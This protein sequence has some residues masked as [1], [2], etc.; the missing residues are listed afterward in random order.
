MI[1]PTRRNNTG[2]ARRATTLIEI[3]VAAAILASLMLVVMLSMSSQAKLGNDMQTRAYGNAEAQRVYK[4][5]SRILRTAA[6][7]HGTSTYT[8][9]AGQYYAAL[10]FRPIRDPAYGAN[11]A[12][13]LELIVADQ[14]SV[15]EVVDPA[16]AVF[17]VAFD[18]SGGATRGG[19]LRLRLPDGSTRVIS[20]NILR[21]RV[22]NQGDYLQIEIAFKISTGEGPNGIEQFV[23][24]EPVAGG[25]IAV[26]AFDV[27]TMRQSP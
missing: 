13:T 21:F 12:G 1:F 17:P 5:V 22:T 14:V 6:V 25:Q 4:E 27:S 2:L 11:V 23:N 9:A 8:P 24:P 3:V 20:H 7:E 18:A 26:L 19:R 10:Q 16:G 15:L